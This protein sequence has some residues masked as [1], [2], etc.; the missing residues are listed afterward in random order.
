M[1]RWRNE[2][3]RRR[4]CQQ[5]E[6]DP[7]KVETVMAVK[8]GHDARATTA[9]VNLSAGWCKSPSLRQERRVRGDGPMTR[10]VRDHAF[11]K[12]RM[13]RAPSTFP[14]ASRTFSAES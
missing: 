14:A 8:P 9:R 7:T 10:A 3:W 4:F 6:I 11:G 13:K 5:S 2:R 12:Q 1:R